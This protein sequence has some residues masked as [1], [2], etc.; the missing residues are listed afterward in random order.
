MS[1]LPRLRK[2]PIGTLAVVI[3]SLLVGMTL[4]PAA[5]QRAGLTEGAVTVRSDG[6]V[7]LISGGQ[8]HWV[9]TVVITDEELN[10]YPEAEPIY[11]G[12]APFGSGSTTAAAKPSGS[13]TTAAAGS[14][15]ATGSTPAATGTAG[16]TAGGAAG[17]TPT[18]DPAGKVKQNG[19]I[20]P[21]SH[22]LKGATVNGVKYYYEPDR[23]EYPNIT[24]EECF[25]AG[26]DARAAGYQERK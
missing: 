19:N 11:A 6:A 14:T 7:Y 18:A 15:P 21:D 4:A 23:V 1:K 10:T 3:G 25:T 2:L 17:P 22:L 16:S 9:A 20:C 12:L 24:P 5:D 13:G 26:G 8:R